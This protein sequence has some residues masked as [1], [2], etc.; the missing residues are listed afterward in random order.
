MF[1][2][3]CE[4]KLLNIIEE[5]FIFEKWHWDWVFSEYFGLISFHQ[6]SIPSLIYMLLLPEG[7]TREFCRSTKR[8]CSMGN[9]EGLDRIAL[10]LFSSFKV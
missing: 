8:Q 7:Q 9:G 5:N 3:R 10:S 4:L 2:A 6:C 1:T